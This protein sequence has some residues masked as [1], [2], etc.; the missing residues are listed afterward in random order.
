LRDLIDS[1]ASRNA[2]IDFP[3]TGNPDEQETIEALD[4]GDSMGS[5]IE[6]KL[7]PDGC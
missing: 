7:R 6:A 3:A 5:K 4:R 2:F 1:N